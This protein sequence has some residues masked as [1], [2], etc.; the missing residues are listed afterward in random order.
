MHAVV[1]SIIVI[2]SSTTLL[3]IK[4]IDYKDFRINAS[5]SCQN[6]YAVLNNLHCLKIQDRFTYKILMLTYKSYYN[7]APTYLYE[8]ISR[9]ESSV[10]TRLEVDHH[11]LIMLP[12][13]TDCS[14]TFLERSFAYAAPCNNNNNNTYLKSNIQCT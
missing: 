6:H 14:N 7:I 13:S 4:Q 2:L 11:Q 3:R 12:I 9:K 8:L 1:E 5:A 10:D